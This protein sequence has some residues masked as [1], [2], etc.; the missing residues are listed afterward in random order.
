MVLGTGAYA[1]T[2]PVMRASSLELLPALRGGTLRVRIKARVAPMLEEKVIFAN[3][4]EVTMSEKTVPLVREL[5]EAERARRQNVSE[6][7]EDMFIIR[8]GWNMTARLLD[9]KWTSFFLYFKF[10]VLRFGV[11]KIGVNGER[12]KLDCSEYLLEDGQGEVPI[13][14]HGERY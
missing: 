14:M 4:G 8:R 1:F 6:G 11:T 9:Q 10:A 7:L 5:N 3:L 12:W 2:A 13:S